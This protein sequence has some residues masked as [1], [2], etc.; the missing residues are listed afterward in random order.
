MDVGFDLYKVF[1]FVGEFK[2]VTK[3]ANYLCV[4]QP[5]VTKHIKNLESLVGTNLIIKVP[6][7]I[8]LSEKGKELFN[9]IEEPISKLVSL[10]IKNLSKNSVI[11]ISAG[12]SIT[13]KYLLNKMIDLNKKYPN[14]TI[15]L[16]N[17]YYR[18][19]VQRLRDG[20]L[21]L[22]FLNLRPNYNFGSDFISRDFCELHDIFVISGKKKLNYPSKIKL[23]DLVKYPVICKY[24]ISNSR[25]FIENYFNQNGYCF[26]VRY[27]VSNHYLIEKYIEE[28]LGIGLVTK[29]FVQD[30]LDSGE[31]I[32]IETDIKLPIRKIVYVIRKNNRYNEILNE[33]IKNIND[34]K[35]KI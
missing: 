31:F 5:A 14:L 25:F 15:S 16:S 24:G 34:Y 33:F 3:A 35:K 8:E 9:E 23:L 2:S 21:D 19:S 10:E 11:K 12:H 7:G 18:E 6:K 29:E 1:Y 13:N 22:I 27:N 26:D 32:E 28:G 4:S 20:K 17:Y 30:K